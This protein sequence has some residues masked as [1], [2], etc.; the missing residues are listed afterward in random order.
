MDPDRIPRIFVNFA[1]ALAPIAHK[2]YNLTLPE[3]KRTAYKESAFLTSLRRRFH[4]TGGGH[5]RGKRHEDA[6][7]TKEA[8]KNSNNSKQ[9]KHKIET[10]P[11]TAEGVQKLLDNCKSSKDKG[12]TKSSNTSR[13]RKKSGGGSS[14][15]TKERAD[16]KVDKK[17]PRDKQETPEAKE[18]PSPASVAVEESE[19][20]RP[21]E[22][23]EAGENGSPAKD[24]QKTPSPPASEAVEESEGKRPPED[25]DE[26]TSPTVEQ[27]KDERPPEDSHETT[28]PPAPEAKEEDGSMPA[29]AA[30]PVEPSEQSSVCP[31]DYVN[32]QINEDTPCPDFE[33]GAD[34]NDAPALASPTLSENGANSPS[35]VQK[36]TSEILKQIEVGFQCGSMV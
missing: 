36:Q 21:Q 28:S 5:K 17:P 15:P 13:A 1:A 20:K 18:K 16:K 7:S 14:Q 34:T 9:T 32:V 8:A 6:P 27:E 10:K 22:T 2:E 23:K 33:E 3:K 12:G 19:A 29:A 26:T 11:V 24:N 25:N 30:D 35:A 31:T 4:V